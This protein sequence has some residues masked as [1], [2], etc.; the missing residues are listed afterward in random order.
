M[1]KRNVRIRR[2]NKSTGLGITIVIVFAICGLVSIKKHSLDQEQTL[3][4]A[5]MENL[6]EEYQEE[7]E[8]AEKLE[9]EE[10][11]MK[12]RQFIEDVARDRFGLIYED[13]YMFSYCSEANLN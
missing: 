4:Y 6:E 13:E 1:K 7:E 11:Y 9:E 8:K 5:H 10:E 12:T 3:A 2:N